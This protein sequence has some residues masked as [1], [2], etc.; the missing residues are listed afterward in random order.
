MKHLFLLLFVPVF[1]FSQ[2]SYKAFFGNLHSH[3][4]N[5]DGE[6]TPQEAFSYA[7]ET[8]K[9]DFLAVTDHLEQI[10]NN[11]WEDVMKQAEDASD[12]TFVGIAGWEW[13]APIIGHCNVYNTTERITQIGWY[14]FNLNSFY[15][16]VAEKGDAFGQFNHP[17]DDDL[18]SN[19]NDMEYKNASIDSA[20]PLIEFQELWQATNW[21]EKALNKGWHLSPGWNQDNHDRNWGT[22]NEY[23]MGI[24]S[25][26]LTRES[27]F[28]GIK[29]GRTFATMDKNAS[30]WLGINGNDMGSRLQK[31]STYGLEL[32]LNDEDGESWEKIELVTNNGVV[33]EL[34]GSS[35]FD[36]VIT[37]TSDEDYYFIRATQTDGDIIWS[38]PV[39]LEGEVT[40]AAN[41]KNIICGP[42]KIFSIPS[43]EL[44]IINTGQN[45]TANLMIS[46]LNGTQIE[47]RQ[48]SG[49]HLKMKMPSLDRGVY[50][51]EV[52]YKTHRIQKH[53]VW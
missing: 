10:D 40:S 30:V 13:G 21:Y 20:F 38:G 3:T 32:Y 2:G 44:L 1:A 26:S 43:Q 52:H 4:G 47:K 15:D 17:D 8:A 37:R 7:K 35:L 41:K 29:K 23:R 25:D 49:P 46:R 9:I 48:V 33:Q 51:L 22:M 39:Y 31:R 6:G 50:L 14:Y 36:T 11:E 12:D 28:N 16:F 5:S 45:G 19:W 34:S 42:V 27:L 24:W 53:F 18:F